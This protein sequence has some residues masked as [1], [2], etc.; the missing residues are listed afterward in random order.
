MFMMFIY[1]DR[2][3]TEKGGLVMEPAA[4]DC[5]QPIVQIKDVSFHYREQQVIKDLNFT[6][7]ERDF[8][9]IVGSNGAGKTT[10]S[11]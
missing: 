2:K 8:V 4:Q 9:G 11:A 5:H 3:T 6:I 7:K 1:L 10:R